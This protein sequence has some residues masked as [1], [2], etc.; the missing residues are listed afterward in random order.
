MVAWVA[1]ELKAAEHFKEDVMDIDIIRYFGA[2]YVMETTLPPKEKCNLIDYIKEA[3]WDQV[4]HLVLNGQKSERKLTINEQYV[5][6]AQAENKIYPL[7][8]RYLSEAGKGKGP[9]VTTQGTKKKAMETMW[10]DVDKGYKYAREKVKKGVEGGKSLSSKHG[11]KV[12]RYSGK[13]GVAV[14]VA[15]ATAAAHRAYKIYLSK[16]GRAC[17][18]TKGTEK[19]EC[20]VKFRKAGYQAKMNSYLK[21]KGDCAKSKNPEACKRRLD[22]KIKKVKYKIGTLY[23]RM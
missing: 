5:L 14:L 12:M 1:E 23:S 11:R 15:A 22:S 2:A 16:A 6:E 20:L 7:I 10:S 18:G 8:L 13:L 17:A 3:T 21:A 4:L 9:K 19:R